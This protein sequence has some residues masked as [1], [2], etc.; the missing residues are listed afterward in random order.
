[1]NR[2]LKLLGAALALT[3][4]TTQAQA[5]KLSNI[6]ADNVFSGTSDMVTD[7]MDTLM[8]GVT[9]VRL[10]I[11]PAVSPE[12]EGSK[13]YQVNALPLISLRYKDLL[14][15]D[16][17]QIRVN[18]FGQKGAMVKSENFRAGPMVKIDFGRK[19]KDSVDLRGLGNVS[20]S[21][22]LGAFASYMT[23]PLQYRIRA[24]QDVASGHKGLLA[25]FD[26]SL[27]V[28][29]TQT[30]I[31]GAQLGTTWAN[32]KYMSKFFG[33]VASQATASGLPVY[34]PGSGLKEVSLSVGSEMKITPRWAIV[35]NAGAERLLSKAKSSPLVS[36]RGSPNQ[37]NFGVYGVYSL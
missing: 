17:N 37:L 34:A 1:M 25:D 15:V 20:T 5:Q 16:N 36:L 22:E 6:F 9:N 21:I 24:R 4:V 12:F 23:G 19:D 8:P 3:A 29:R 32:S 11:G 35:M 30:T 13:H 2:K 14:Q 10:G 28:Y 18:V 27:A 33:V 26:V 7:V 31:V